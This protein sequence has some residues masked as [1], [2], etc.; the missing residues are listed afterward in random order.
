MTT[1]ST[2]LEQLESALARLD[3]R[4]TLYRGACRECGW[5][6]R[7][8]TTRSGAEWAGGK[9]AARTGHDTLGVIETA[10]GPNP[11]PWAWVR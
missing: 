5:H 4:P 11:S 6:G 10:T 8:L 1:N 9:H 3:Q 7:T 2:P